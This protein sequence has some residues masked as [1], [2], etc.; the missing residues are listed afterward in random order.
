LERIY[1]A[2]RAGLKG[3]SLAVATGMT[4]SDY[5]KL[6]DNDPHVEMAEAKGR[7]DSELEH[8]TNLAEASRN[9]DARASLEILKHL[10]GWVAKQQVE[11]TTTT[12]SIKDLLELRE[13]QI[14]GV[15]YEHDGSA[16][17]DPATD[18]ESRLLPVSAE[19]RV[20]GISMDSRRP[21]S[22]QRAEEVAAEG[23]A[24]DRGL[25]QDRDQDEGRD[26]PSA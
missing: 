14:K 20:M 17:A 16:V 4:P 6:R 2:A 26:R 19:V 24:G 21:E 23:D 15:L 3:D 18:A 7:A 8:A 22:L 10:H 25:S 9:G 5:R 11:V 13:Q 1:H 12:A